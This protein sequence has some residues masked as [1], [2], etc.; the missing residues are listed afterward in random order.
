MSNISV[1]NNLIAGTSGYLSQTEQKPETTPAGATT[2]NSATTSNNVDTHGPA[3]TV[4]LSAPGQAAAN[5]QSPSTSSGSG[6][7]TNT[8]APAP[9]HTNEAPATGQAHAGGGGGGGGA[10]SDLSTLVTEAKQQVAAQ[11]GVVD[12]NFLV[13]SQGNIDEVGLQK[14]LA[15]QQSSNGG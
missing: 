10:S 12:A 5:S 6:S 9:I 1:V 4:D 2:S 3:T 8:N 7:S 15:A 13:D 11:V 14:D